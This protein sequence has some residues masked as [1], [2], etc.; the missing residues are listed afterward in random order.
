MSKWQNDGMLDSALAYLL[1]ATTVHLCS[2]QPTTYTEAATTYT[3]GYKVVPGGAIGAPADA[4]SGRQ[5]TISGSTIGEIDITATGSATHVAFVSASALI[6]VTTCSSR[7]VTAGDK[8]EISSITINVK[9][10]I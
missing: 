6:Y 9:D 10:A 8:V 4:T 3:L 1:N 5:I 7:A 2:A